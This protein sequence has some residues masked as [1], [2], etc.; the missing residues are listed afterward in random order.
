MKRVYQEQNVFDA[1][2]DRIRGLYDDFDNIVVSMSGGKDST[3]VLHLAMIVAKEKG[4]LPV[5][6][7]FIDQE[8][9]WVAT[10][11]YVREV[12]HTPGVNPFWLQVPFRLFNA[13]S[14][15]EQWLHCW[16]PEEEER[17]MR[18]KEPDSIHENIYGTDRF[19]PMF[20]RW[21]RVQFGNQKVCNLIGLRAEE[22]PGRRMGL[23][24]VATYKDITW[25][26]WDG[27]NVIAF[28]PLY[29]WSYTDIWK[30]IHDNGWPYCSLYDA[31]Y[32]YGLPTARMRVSS[33]HHE[34]AI[35]SLYYLQE[36]E[37]DTW[38]RLTHRIAG[39]H[40]AGMLGTGFTHVKELPF[41]FGSWPEYRDYLMENL[42]TDVPSRDKMANLFRTSERNV[43]P[44]FME[45]L[46]RAQVHSVLVG[47]YHG[48]IL[49][50]WQ[51][52]H[53]RPKRVKEKILDHG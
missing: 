52:A 20:R 43:L 25:C 13:S 33:L 29:D 48:T 26:Y 30:A 21:C 11:D 10:I 45:D 50:T 35:R 19:Y 36:I 2:L 18:P 4:R 53:Y 14:P 38:E 8:A 37:P 42:V 12:M 32:Q 7:L 22:S 23:T 47:D 44:E 3:V 17:W 41:M 5:D 46:Y 49:Q 51:A 31:M 40:S 27:N 9:E 34:Q 15:T 16:A 24:G 28:S 1:A 39:V 6:V